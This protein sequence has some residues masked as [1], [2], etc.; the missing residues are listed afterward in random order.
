MLRS[1]S[2]GAEMDRIVERANDPA[3]GSSLSARAA[4]PATRR[5]WNAALVNEPSTG[6][7]TPV[8]TAV[9]IAPSP[10]PLRLGGA[11]RHWETLRRSSRT[12]A[13]RPT[14]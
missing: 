5:S 13:W 8:R 9:V 6:G 1:G 2:V 10:V 11:E 7:P 4:P 3:V 14:W 12:L